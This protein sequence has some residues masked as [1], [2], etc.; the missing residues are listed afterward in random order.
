MKKTAL[1][2]AV[3]LTAGMNLAAATVEG[4][5]F[6]DDNGNGKQDAG[7][8]ALSGFLVSDGLNFARTDANGH[9]SLNVGEKQKS[10]YVHQPKDYRAR[11]WYHQIPTDRK[12]LD[13]AMQPARPFRGMFLQ[14]ADSETESIDNFLP[15]VAELAQNLQPDFVVHTGDL[16]R[17]EG[18]K[19][20]AENFTEEKI[21]VPVYVTPGN[22]DIVKP[23]DGKD[24]S[25]FFG[26]YYYSFE[27]G[28]Y[29]VV[30][31][32]MSYGDVKLPYELAD[33]GDY[34]QKLFQMI[35]DNKP[36]V[37]IGHFLLAPEEEKLIA[38]HNGLKVDLNKH[39]FQTW[40]YGHQHHNIAIRYANG[41]NAY[42]TSTP[43][44]GG[45]DHS[46]TSFRVITTSGDKQF[47][48][49]LI[50][51]GMNNHLSITVPGTNMIP[52]ADRQ[53][54]VSVAA[55]HTGAP[56]IAVNAVLSENGKQIGNAVLQCVN[57]I[58]WNGSLSVPPN[59]AGKTLHLK[60]TATRM[61]GK[62]FEKTQSFVWSPPEPVKTPV[63]GEWNN[64]LGNAEHTGYW[65]NL[66]IPAVQ[67]QWLQQMPGENAMVSPI[68]AEGKV[69]VGCMD[70]HEAKRG[71]IY[72]YD[73]ATGKEVW[74]F[75]TG[76]SIKNSIASGKGLIFAQD[77]HGYIYALRIADGTLAWKAKPAVRDS[78][79]TAGIVYANGILYAGQHRNLAA[80]DASSGKM[81]W[82]DTAA[83]GW[84]ATV[85]TVS[86]EN[87][88]LVTS[89]NWGGLYGLDATT[90]KLLWKHD[91]SDIRTQAAS[92]V[93]H[94]GKIYAKGE[95]QLFELEPRTG[96]ILRRQQLPAGLHSATAPVVAD[97]LIL[98][99]TST[100]GLMAIDLKTFAIRWECKEIQP[101]LLDTAP[102]HWRTRTVESSPVVLGNTIWI[103]AN[104]GFLYALDLQTGRLKQ[105]LDV[106]TPILTTAAA[107]NGWLWVTDFG[108]RVFGFRAIDNRGDN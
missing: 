95:Y 31:S 49:R 74:H 108:G 61:D 43:N 50:W 96:K 100:R 17:I 7:E 21:G 79:V 65:P 54:P 41:A 38:G 52:E 102:Y 47:G 34:L 42:C 13:F 20:H 105:K 106:G 87:G 40:I 3:C 51:G 18:M 58:I 60:V 69:F 81:L 35:P 89:A 36:L 53:I 15:T 59:A 46:P 44:K 37:M 93:F 64:L 107:S 78:A 56:V 88:V 10:I 71:G 97:G 91:D 77:S 45:L 26:P 12:S 14:L 80:Y 92:A 98:V 82:R 101:A 48:S 25:S 83:T 6:L 23:V 11:H 22:H 75:T 8:R 63:A 90:G 86:V 19:A 55:Y 39:N 28:P 76:N 103:G 66:S 24:Y 30:A 33:F 5:V 2:S 72:A 85:N 94:D 62:A 29:L 68:L 1:I 4:N 67:L 84:L 16:C 9:Y 27:W 70:D 73:A 99:G 57:S 32:P 104:D